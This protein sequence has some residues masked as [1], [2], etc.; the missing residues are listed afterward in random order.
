MS[1]PQGH[2]V[3]FLSRDVI[4]LEGDLHSPV[5]ARFGLT[6]LTTDPKRDICLNPTDTL[7]EGHYTGLAK[8]ADSERRQF[9]VILPMIKIDGKVYEIPRIE[10][11]K[12]SGFGVFGP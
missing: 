8:F 2:S 6:R 12:K 10:F 4:L 1:I 5:N 3:S 11:G 9:Y 7:N